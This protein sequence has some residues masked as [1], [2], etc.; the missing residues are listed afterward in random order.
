MAVA[1]LVS[2]PWAR[3]Q[4]HAYGHSP[5]FM[6]KAQT[7]LW[8][9]RTDPR[10]AGPRAVRDTTARF[11]PLTSSQFVAREWRLMREQPAPYLSDYLSEYV[12]FFNPLPDRVLTQN[13]YTSSVF[14]LIAAA[15]FL[16]VLLLATIG[17]VMGAAT[18]RDR[19]L[20]ALIPLST[21]G[22]Y[23]LFFTQMRYRIPTE[24]QILIL[25][26]LGFS[27]LLPRLSSRIAGEG[28]QADPSPPA[29]PERAP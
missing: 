17:F 9:V 12:H 15:Y 28:F 20:L 5:I 23:A 7:V 29:T 19:T 4:R 26:A 13:V 21:A 27:R 22:L 24:P 25:A 18:L 10:L 16:P 2:L 6:E 3:Y 14:K 8:F 11:T 1:V